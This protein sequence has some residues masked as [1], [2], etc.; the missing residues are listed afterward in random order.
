[1][2]G[3]GELRI[4]L[5]LPYNHFQLSS[6]DG[7]KCQCVSLCG[8]EFPDLWRKEFLFV[9]NCQTPT[10]KYV[11]SAKCKVS[12]M[13]SPTD[14]LNASIDISV[15]SSK[16]KYFFSYQGASVLWRLCSHKRYR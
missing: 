16:N 2:V 5:L 15:R 14:S 10:G 1:M 8:I 9:L 6:C 13:G 3:S 7:P 4:A 11:L 12:G